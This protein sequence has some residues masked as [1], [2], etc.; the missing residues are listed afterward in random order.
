MNP[1]SQFHSSALF[2]ALWIYILGMDLSKSL[3]GAEMWLG[4]VVAICHRT[5]AVHRLSMM[6]CAQ[7]MKVVTSLG[8]YV[9]GQWDSCHE[10]C[11][12]L[13][14]CIRYLFVFKFG[15]HHVFQQYSLQNL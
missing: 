1:R 12:V 10:N 7:Q 4:T 5:M 14:V 9:Q 3:G 11:A 15:G 13:Y 6:V 8:L 2:H